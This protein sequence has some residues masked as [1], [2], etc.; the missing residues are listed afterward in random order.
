MGHSSYIG[1]GT[2]AKWL[3]KSDKLS[4]RKGIMVYNWLNI[5]QF[6]LL[7]D[8]RCDPEHSLCGA[9]EAD[10][11]WLGPQCTVCALPLHAGGLICGQCLKRPPAFDQVVAPWRDRK[12]TRLNSSHVKISY[13]VF[14]LKKKKTTHNHFA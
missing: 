3:A 12:S 10:L 6:C 14:C 7:C 11:P 1:L 4:T 13:A 2:E 5:E 9:C 8:E